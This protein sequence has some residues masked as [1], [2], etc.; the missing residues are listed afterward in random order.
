VAERES[1]ETAKKGWEAGGRVG[2]QGGRF[3]DKE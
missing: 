2:M 3:K 1:W